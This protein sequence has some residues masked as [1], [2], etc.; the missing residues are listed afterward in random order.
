M[1]FRYHGSFCGPGWSDGQY[2]A[3]AA[4]FATPV[5]YF[6][7][8]C[9]DHDRAIGNGDDR[10]TA[11]LEFARCALRAGRVIESIA[12]PVYGL[13]AG[14]HKMVKNK[15]TPKPPTFGKQKVLMIAPPTNKKNANNGNDS[16]IA[17]PVSIATKRTSKSAK[18]VNGPD[19][20]IRVSH[21]AFIAP[22][23]CQTN[24]TAI[25]IPCNPGL[26]GSFPWLSKLARKY[27]MYRV[28]SLKYMYRSVTATSTP[29]V[30]M[31]S[32]DYDAA[33]ELPTSKAKQAQTVPCVET[34]CWATMDLPV[35]CDGTW[36]YVR[37]G[38]LSPNLD[39]KT[40]DLGNLVIS[41]IY[42]TGV[43]TGEI[44]VEYTVELKKPSDGTDDSST[45]VFST[46]NFVTPF[47]NPST[48]TGYS[49]VIPDSTTPN[50]TLQFVTSGDWVFIYQSTGT[51]LTSS[52]GIPTIATSGSGSVV[53]LI[54]NF[55]TTVGIRICKVRAEYGDR[56]TLASAGNGT[57]LTSANVR[58]CPADFDNMV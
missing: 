22:L 51:G 43:V 11:D 54:G 15:N 38:A 20:S 34:N 45:Q 5:S 46:T 31:F 13:L 50:T 47:A 14:K 52:P 53:S 55:G 12:V 32:F 49:P 7:A 58:F 35:K 18:V 27:D 30:I 33:D 37:P 48:L 40:Y 1:N 24:F 26:S 44:Y 25:K 21:R 8:C 2:K 23:G 3:D 9:K 17:A 29:G 36:R 4:G 16:K 42:G 10:F 39:V 19:G 56:L 57:T 6:D 28:V 41:S